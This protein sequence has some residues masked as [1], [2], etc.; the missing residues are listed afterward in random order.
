M[1]RLTAEP[2]FIRR[3]E[4][5]MFQMEAKVPSPALIP[6]FRRHLEHVMFQARPSTRAQARPTRATLAPS[7]Y[8]K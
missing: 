3:L 7:R 1:F 5:R 2:E 4:R 8:E 6:P